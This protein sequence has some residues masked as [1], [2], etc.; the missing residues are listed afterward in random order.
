[1]ASLLED[2]KAV[3][4]EIRL[5]IAEAAKEGDVIHPDVVAPYIASAYP[6]ST[7]GLGEISARIVAD[8]LAS[9]LPVEIGSA[10]GQVV[11]LT[12]PDRLYC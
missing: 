3:L 1:M 11:R 5:L 8:A 6:S 4:E 10:D 9:G 7:Y 12:V 2:Q